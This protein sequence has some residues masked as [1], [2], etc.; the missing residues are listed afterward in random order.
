MVAFTTMLIIGTKVFFWGSEL[1]AELMRCGTCGKRCTV[2]SKEG[3]AIHHAIF[4][5]S[6][7]PNQ[8]DDARCGMPAVQDAIQEVVADE[9]LLF[10]LT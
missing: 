6:N 1:T 8:R 2:Y 7:H 3:N 5:Y 10:V 9:N 4:H